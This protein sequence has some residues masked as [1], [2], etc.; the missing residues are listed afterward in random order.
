[1]SKKVRFVRSVFAALAFIC[2]FLLLGVGGAIEWDEL[3]LGVGVF[4]M[5]C[6]G[7]LAYIFSCKAGLFEP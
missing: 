2:A 3:P 4:R 1:M 5:L 6:F 7:S